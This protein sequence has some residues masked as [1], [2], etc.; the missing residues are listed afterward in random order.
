MNIDR[1]RE[2]AIHLRSI[3]PEMFDMDCWGY[4][5]CRMAA[6]IAGH[7][8]RL[9]PQD[10]QYSTIAD[11]A[12]YV[13]DLDQG[14]ADQLF[15]PDMSLDEFLHVTPGTAAK[16]LDHLADTGDVEWPSEDA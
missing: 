3:Q 14:I 10:Y 15:L 12:A 11:H 7:A 1:I 5:G 16:V 8:S 9:W 2:L 4:G 6:C 13:L